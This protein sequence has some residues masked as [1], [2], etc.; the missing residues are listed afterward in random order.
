MACLQAAGVAD[1]MK[2]TRPYQMGRSMARVDEALEHG[3]HDEIDCL[4]NFDH[5]D[6]DD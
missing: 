4:R 2:D 3:P 5:T 1:T 6:S